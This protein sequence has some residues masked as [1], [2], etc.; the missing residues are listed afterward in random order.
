LQT[1]PSD[2]WQTLKSAVITEDKSSHAIKCTGKPNCHLN[3]LASYTNICIHLLLTAIF[4]VN[5]G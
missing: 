1:G 4:Q 3:E 5:L 2:N